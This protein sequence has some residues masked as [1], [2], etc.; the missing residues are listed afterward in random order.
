MNLAHI[1]AIVFDL[2]G[3]L[4]DSQL[5]FAAIC[6]DIGW[7]R[8]TPLLEKL[9]TLGQTAEAARANEIIRMHELAGARAASWMPGAEACLQY[10]QQQNYPLAI[11][12]RN[13]REATTLMLNRLQ[14]P[15][16]L[17]LTR[18][19]CA[20]KPDPEGLL[21][22]AKQLEVP[23]QHM[24]YVGDYIFDLQVAANAGARSCLY[25]NENNQVFIKD[26]D[27]SITHFSELAR[28]F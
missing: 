2:D 12:T 14:I 16:S 27:Y 1:N 6:D 4:V 17:V 3:T 21:L 9:A 19:D 18:E 22:I 13:M 28:A 24:L 23:C 7:P 25:L 11:L 5:N 20:A 8:G 26:A 15:I 10:L